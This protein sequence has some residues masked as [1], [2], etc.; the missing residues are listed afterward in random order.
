MH[1]SR[2]NSEDYM[3]HE[4]CSELRVHSTIKFSS[5]WIYVTCGN[6]EDYMRNEKLI[7]LM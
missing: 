3:R 6:I 1:V 4:E 5:K 2:G 7:P